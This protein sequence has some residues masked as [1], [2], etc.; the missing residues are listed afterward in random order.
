M[1]R[2]TVVQAAA[3]HQNVASF[4]NETASLLQITFVNTLISQVLAFT[5]ISISGPVTQNSIDDHC[6]KYNFSHCDAN[7]LNTYN[8]ADECGAHGYNELGNNNYL[9]IERANLG[10]YRN[11]FVL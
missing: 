7:S 1:H 10:I 8:M 2:T 6:E 9:N 11:P 5:T 4:A 3:F